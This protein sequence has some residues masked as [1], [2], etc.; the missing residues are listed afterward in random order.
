[1]ILYIFFDY[2]IIAIK[3]FSS[4]LIYLYDIAIFFIKFSNS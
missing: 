1:M 2:T 3:Y 4:L